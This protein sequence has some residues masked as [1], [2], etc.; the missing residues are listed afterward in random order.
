MFAGAEA[1]AAAKAKKEGATFGVVAKSLKVGKAAFFVTSSVND[2]GMPPCEPG[3]ELPLVGPPVCSPE[4]T[5][6]KFTVIGWGPYKGSGA[7][8]MAS[9]A[10][11]AQAGDVTLSHMITLVKDLLSGKI[12]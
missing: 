3:A 8:T 7:Q 2:A 10:A 9:T 12:H 4:P 6:A 11:T 5:L 1:S